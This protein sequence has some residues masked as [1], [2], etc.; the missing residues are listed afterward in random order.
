MPEEIVKTCK[1]LV[2]A[3]RGAFAWMAHALSEWLFWLT[4][5]GDGHGSTP[6]PPNAPWQLSESSVHKSYMHSQQGPRGKISIADQVW[7]Q[8]MS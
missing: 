8:I 7:E 5:P 6:A 4:H 1:R 3:A 2:K